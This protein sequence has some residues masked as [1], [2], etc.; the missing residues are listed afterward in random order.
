MLL[1]LKEKGRERNYESKL[2]SLSAIERVEDV[3]VSPVRAEHEEL[4][5][6]KMTMMIQNVSF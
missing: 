5:I 3:D 4:Q 2:V 1:K 6:K